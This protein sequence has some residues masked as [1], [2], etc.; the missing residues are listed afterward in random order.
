MHFG[1]RYRQSDELN[2]LKNM[3]RRLSAMS[4]KQ[5]HNKCLEWAKILATRKCPF[6]LW[7]FVVHWIS[8]VILCFFE[9]VQPIQS[10]LVA[11]CR[12]NH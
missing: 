12:I 8:P 2:V 7:I 6:L 10:S 11:V 4:D 5:A 3:F 9:I 1:L